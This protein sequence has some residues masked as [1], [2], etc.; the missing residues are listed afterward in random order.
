M[1]NKIQK[2]F[3]NCSKI[4]QKLNYSNIFQNVQKNF[5]NCFKNCSKLFNIFQIIFETWCENSC[6]I[7]YVHAGDSGSVGKAFN[8]R[9]WG[10][11]SILGK[12]VRILL[13][14]ILNMIDTNN[15][16]PAWSW[17]H[18]KAQLKK[19]TSTMTC[20]VQ[21]RDKSACLFSKQTYFLSLF[22]KLNFLSLFSKL[23][24]MSLFYELDKIILFVFNKSFWFS[25]KV[26]FVILG[27]FFGV[28]KPPAKITK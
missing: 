16:A 8:S 17:Q 23:Y 5:K 2:L 6:D 20:V 15:P 21:K 22:V 1:Q 10:P 12:C 19:A 3:K 25:K 28:P 24:F 7:E 26:C 4:I 9:W 14:Y 11:G 13:W 18:W 27:S